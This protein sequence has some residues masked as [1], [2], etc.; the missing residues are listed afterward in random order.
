[1]TLLQKLKQLQEDYGMRFE[2]RIHI[3]DQYVPPTSWRVSVYAR[4][5]QLD[6]FSRRRS[7]LMVTHEMKDEATIIQAL[8][9]LEGKL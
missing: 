3:W 9:A 8:V 5:K 2:F 4:Y 1:M 7:D 6:H